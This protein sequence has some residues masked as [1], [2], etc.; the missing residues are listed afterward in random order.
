M[1][2]STAAN[3]SSAQNASK[4]DS[5]ATDG[6]HRPADACTR[7]Q[8]DAFEN[9]LRVRSHEERGQPKQGDQ[10]PSD[11]A[12]AGLAAGNACFPLPLRAATIPA[13][14]GAPR[15]ADADP[16]APRA[17]IEAALQ[18]HVPAP[19]TAVG[20]ADPA[21]LWEA[22][23]REPNAIAVD[24]KAFRAEKSAHETQAAWSVSVSSPTVD[25]EVLSRHASRLNER[26]KKQAAEFTH[27]RIERDEP[28]A[29]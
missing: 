1:N 9:A 21:A 26:L 10:E 28:E 12:M 7:E 13:P 18:A 23:V 22:S 17:K 19:I 15:A 6:A 27:V 24:V 29:E 8:R 20:E 14:A 2:V 25:A 4:A 16:S 5:A 11:E 3:A